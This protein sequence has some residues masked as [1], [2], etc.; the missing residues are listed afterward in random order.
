[1]Y[2]IPIG[3]KLHMYIR[4]FNGIAAYT[5]HNFITTYTYIHLCIIKY[6]TGSYDMEASEALGIN[7]H[8]IVFNL[9]ICNNV[10]LLFGYFKI[11]AV[12]F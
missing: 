12:I 8:Y 3:T 11:Y 1:M 9:R 6:N 5:L 4:T 7:S 10:L 2:I